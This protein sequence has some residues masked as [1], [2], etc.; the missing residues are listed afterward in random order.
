MVLHAL[1]LEHPAHHPT[2]IEVVVEK[3]DGRTFLVLDDGTIVDFD[4]LELD[5]ATRIDD[6]ALGLAA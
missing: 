5:V 1:K 3:R 2:R 4:A 6:R